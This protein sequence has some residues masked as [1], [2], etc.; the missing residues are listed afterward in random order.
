MCLRRRYA[1]GIR[2]VSNRILAETAA[3]SKTARSSGTPG[4]LPSQALLGG[5]AL[6]GGPGPPLQRRGLPLL[7]GEVGLVLE[8]VLHQLLHLPERGLAHLL[9]AV[10]EEEDQRPD[11]RLV[12]ERAEELE[13][14]R[15][16]QPLDGEDAVR[17]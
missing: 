16:P 12:L 2:P 15:L 7:L 6:G 17:E 13:L 3:A 10:L 14:H 9:V 5:A 11:G 1:V 8:G 4:L